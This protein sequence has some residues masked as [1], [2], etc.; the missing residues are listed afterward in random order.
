[1]RGCE[2]VALGECDPYKLSREQEQEKREKKS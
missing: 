2:I 1:M